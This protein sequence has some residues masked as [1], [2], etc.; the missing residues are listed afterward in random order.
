MKKLALGLLILSLHV[1]AGFACVCVDMPDIT[2]TDKLK[3]AV[4]DADAIFLGSVDRFDFLQGVPNEYLEDERKT[5][6]GLTWETKTAVFK[7]DSWWKGPL[8]AEASI[9]TDMTR[10]SD[11]TS[12]ASSCDYG[13]EKG[14]T[15]L[16]F[17]RKHGGY[18][19]NIA[20]SFTRRQ[21][22]I[23]EILPLLG[24]SKNPIKP[25]PQE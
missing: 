20:C 14:K 7:V 23:K 9:A 25:D 4:K 12:S 21:D 19:K 5:N 17:A 18:M 1:S 6:P 13:F 24:E 3:W 10:N 15:Y 2:L 11:G 22:Q 16:V 8:N